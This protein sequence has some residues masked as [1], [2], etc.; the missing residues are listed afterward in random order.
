[1]S[2][3]YKKTIIY[4]PYFFS[5]TYRRWYASNLKED[6]AKVNKASYL[7][8]PQAVYTVTPSNLAKHSLSYCVPSVLQT[9]IYI[10]GQA[11]LI[12]SSSLVQEL[13]ITN[14]SIGMNNDFFKW[15]A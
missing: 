14:K 7:V 2:N 1:M 10:S 15:T 9:G 12:D 4:I 8:S 11:S 6:A 13:I 3:Q 5:W